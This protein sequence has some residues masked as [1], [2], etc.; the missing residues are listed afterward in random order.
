MVLGGG[1]PSPLSNP[2]CNDKEI[3]AWSLDTDGGKHMQKR[4]IDRH[5]IYGSRKVRSLA[6]VW[7]GWATRS[8]WMEGGFVMILVVRFLSMLMLGV[9]FDIFE[10]FCEWRFSKH[11]LLSAVLNSD[12]FPLQILCRCDPRMKILYLYVTSNIIPPSP[13]LGAS[14]TEKI[15]AIN[16]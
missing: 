7:R 12:I 3:G 16:R 6:G 10:F 13:A 8:N 15:Q 5:K 11:H 9:F 1:S 4:K 2:N 14:S